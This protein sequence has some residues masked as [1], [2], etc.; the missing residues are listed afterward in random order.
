MRLRFRAAAAAAPFEPQLLILDSRILL[1]VFENV[2]LGRSRRASLEAAAGGVWVPDT[3]SYSCQSYIIIAYFKGIIGIVEILMKFL[4]CTGKL[5]STDFWVIRT[6]RVA[7]A[8]LFAS[9]TTTGLAK[10]FRKEHVVP[11]HG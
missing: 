3:F 11:E 10:R 6:D 2:S 4:V 7:E 8:L 1:M 9:M 5:S